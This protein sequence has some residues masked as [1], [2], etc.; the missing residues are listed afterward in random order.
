MGIK[1]HNLLNY[2]LLEKRK[3]RE[4]V[5]G[6]FKENNMKIADTRSNKQDQSKV[7]IDL[8]G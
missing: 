3:D 7:K 5:A 6:V 4:T 8:W 1:K 2:F